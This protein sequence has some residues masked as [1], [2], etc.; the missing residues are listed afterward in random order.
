MCGCGICGAVCGNASKACHCLSLRSFAFIWLGISVVVAMAQFVAGSFFSSYLSPVDKILHD[1]RES[2]MSLD[3]PTVAMSYYSIVADSLSTLWRV[4]S[5]IT[6]VR[7]VYD[8]VAL[9]CWVAGWYKRKMVLVY[10][11]IGMMAVDF[12]V[13]LLLLIIFLTLINVFYVA[14]YVLHLLLSH[15]YVLGEGGNGTEMKSWKELQDAKKNKP[16]KDIEKAPLLDGEGSA[17][18]A[19]AGVAPKPAADEVIVEAAS[20]DVP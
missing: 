8:I 1:I 20:D 18:K 11:F 12:A 15:A 13:D 17:K 9:V 7:G 14:P 6:T 10:V 5:L 2:I 3:N 16:S 4:M 19:T